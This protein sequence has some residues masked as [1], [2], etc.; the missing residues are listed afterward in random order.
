MQIVVLDSYAADQGHL[1]WQ[2]LE[3][4]GTVKVY[5]RTSPREVLARAAGADALLT[6]KVVLD[7]EVLALLPKLRY[8]GVLATGTNVV[9]L[10]ACHDRGIT[11]TNVP[12][13]A[14]PSVAQLVFAYVLHF[15]QRVI[16]HDQAVKAGRWAASPDF[17]FTLAPL[18]ELGGK[19]M[20]VIGLGAIGSAVAVLAR[21]FRMSVVAAAV[22]GSPT[23]GRTPL[24]EALAAADFVTLHCPLTEHTAQLV[25]TDFFARMK[26]GAI[27]INTGRGGLVDESALMEALARGRLGGAALDVLGTEPP[28]ADH[29]LLDPSAPW[30]RRLIVTPHLGWASVEARS[31]LIRIAC[32]NL[33]A[34]LGGEAGTAEDRAQAQ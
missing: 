3:A 25:S 15:C 6:N 28:A 27:L 30:A 11:V 7:A 23:E 22:P 20:C 4:F 9:D 19:T 12:G 31:R 10:D 32:E 26:P 16:E 24:F 2:A 33:G 13:Y 34:F 8:V 14:A 29:P 1:G 5:P 21:A 17:C 18:M